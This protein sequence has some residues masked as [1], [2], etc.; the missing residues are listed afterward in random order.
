MDQW[1]QG[2]VVDEMG[3]K[4]VMVHICLRQSSMCTLKMI[5]DH[6]WYLIAAPT[7]LLGYRRRTCRRLFSQYDN[8]PYAT[9]NGEVTLYPIAVFFFL[10]F[11]DTDL[12][13]KTDAR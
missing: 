3:S 4:M 9:D 10:R 2:W 12:T 1:D 8:W 13:I 7:I 11:I 6:Q 5:Y